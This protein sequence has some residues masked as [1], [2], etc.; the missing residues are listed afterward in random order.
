M[1]KRAHTQRLVVSQSVS[2]A[3]VQIAMNCC[4]STQIELSNNETTKKRARAR[5]Q[6]NFISLCFEVNS[7]LHLVA[8]EFR[9]LFIFMRQSSSHNVQNVLCIRNRISIAFDCYH[10]HAHAQF[11]TRPIRSKWL[12][13]CIARIGDWFCFAGR[14]FLVSLDG[15]WFASSSV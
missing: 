1:N 15:I 2:P 9:S 7:T 12:F 3:M 13:S 10:L 14:M 11:I 8:F 4:I 5:E 6:N